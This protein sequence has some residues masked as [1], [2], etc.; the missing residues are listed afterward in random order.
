MAERALL[1]D[2]LM[3]DAPVAVD[4]VSIE[5]R[6]QV[7]HRRA[8]GPGFAEGGEGVGRARASRRDEH[9]GFAGDACIGVGGEACSLLVAANDVL[10]VVGPIERVVHREVVD[11]GNAEDGRHPGCPQCV[12]DRLAAGNGH[13]VPSPSSMNAATV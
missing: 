5:L 3:D 7:E 4:Q 2:Q 13:P 1:V 8:V 6:C 12:D 9:A 10:D 11:A